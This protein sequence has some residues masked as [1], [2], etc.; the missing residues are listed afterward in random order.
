MSELTEA[1]E[2]IQDW[3]ETNNPY[4]F[5]RLRAGLSRDEIGEL[6]KDLPF[7]VP[8]E[9]YE[10]Y[11]WHDGSVDRFIRNSYNFMSLKEAINAYQEEVSENSYNA[12]ED[13]YFFEQSFPVFQLWYQGDVF[14]TIITSGDN[15]GKVLL[16]DPECS[17]YSLQ[18][19]NLTNLIK[20]GAEWCEV[21]SNYE[22]SRET[23]NRDSRVEA[24]LDTK[25]MLREHITDCVSKNRGSLYQLE[26]YKK[27]IEN[28]E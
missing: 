12:R 8:E 16:Y 18:Y 20:H 27:F 19:P 7:T 2:S 25:Y 28:I 17:S 4:E 15:K 10:L 11:Q 24:N 26:V 1:L 22:E 14:Y 23:N 5:S 21:H 6:V 13:A 3:L 9:I